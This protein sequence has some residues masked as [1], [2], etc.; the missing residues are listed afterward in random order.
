MTPVDIVMRARNDMPLITETLEALAGQTLPWR[1]IAFDNSS[2]DGTREALAAAGAL[3]IDVAP[4]DYVP[5]RILN[6]GAQLS[7]GGIVVYLNSDCAPQD[8]R[9]REEIV[10]PFSDPM[11]SAVFSRQVPRPGCEPL[12]ALDTENTF[13]DGSKQKTWRHCF[14]MASSAIRRSVWE[15]MPFDTSLGYSED[16]DWSWRVRNAGGSVLYA[17]GSVVMHSHNYSLS[18][19]YRRQ[20]GEGKAEA[21]IFEWTPWQRSTVRYSLLPYA[22]QVVRDLRYCIPH[23]H[24]GSMVYSPALRLAQMLGRRAGFLAGIKCR[25]L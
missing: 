19:F 23:G 21:A 5:G 9:W 24:I 2:T 6:E 11:V 12:F 15:T 7:Q 18:A 22:R 16:I 1:L 25:P 4:G 3:I 8:A 10:A 13:G 17:P 14:S 20:Y